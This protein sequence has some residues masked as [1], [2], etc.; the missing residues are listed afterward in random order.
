M[1]E[2]ITAKYDS[3]CSLSGELI[4]RGE[5]VYYDYA[6][7]TLIHPRYYENITSQINSS[8]MKSYFERHRKL[9]KIK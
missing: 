8:G 2:L 6:S 7:K 3:V 9:N 5:Q 4:K 1:H